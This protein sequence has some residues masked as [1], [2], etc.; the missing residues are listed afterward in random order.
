MR[1]I[2]TASEYRSI[3]EQIKQL[4]HRMWML[5]A[6]RGNLDPEVIRLS[7]EIDE[8]IVSVQMYWRAQS[9]NESMIG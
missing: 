4:K 7:Q 9:G 1:S 8:H 5:A 3:I 6:Q 2:R